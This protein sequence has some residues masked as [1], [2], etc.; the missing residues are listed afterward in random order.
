MCDDSL[1]CG[2]PL[3]YVNKQTSKIVNMLFTSDRR[4]P[5]YLIAE[6]VGIFTGNIHSILK[7]T[8]LLKK[9]SA[10]IFSDFQWQI[11]LTH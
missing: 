5:V 2:R 1:H 4:L 6:S 7:K 9:V 8:L 10:Q 11:E 3:S